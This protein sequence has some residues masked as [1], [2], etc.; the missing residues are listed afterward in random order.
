MDRP[1]FLHASV[2]TGN[3]RVLISSAVCLL[4]L[5]SLH[6]QVLVLLELVQ[7]KRVPFR[8]SKPIAQAYLELVV[9]RKVARGKVRNEGKVIAHHIALDR[10]AYALDVARRAVGLLVNDR[11]RD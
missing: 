8:K 7:L 4:V 11:T 10:A 5:P 1:A 6:V 3:R 2:V 9:R